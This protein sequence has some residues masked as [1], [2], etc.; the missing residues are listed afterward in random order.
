M[1]NNSVVN[2]L[3][4]IWNG[5]KNFL[6]WCVDVVTKIIK[7][8]LNFAL[9]VVDYF[10]NLTLDPRK[11]TPFIGKANSPEF[12]EMLKKTPV[13]DVGIFE[14]VYNDETDEIENMQIIEADSLDEKTKEVLGTESLVVLK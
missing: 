5:I 13:K 4:S 12:R 9:E 2:F 3:S 8:V 7:G 1:G 6:A 14:G 10:R 11:Q